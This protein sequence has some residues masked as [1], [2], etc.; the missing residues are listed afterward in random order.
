MD[1][2]SASCKDL[3]I[4]EEIDCKRYSST[5]VM[6]NFSLNR[7]FVLQDQNLLPPS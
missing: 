5:V 3:A 6:E 4:R 7:F 1:D 2:T